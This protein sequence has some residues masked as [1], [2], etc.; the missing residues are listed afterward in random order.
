MVNKTHKIMSKTTQEND[1]NRNH[2]R[3][4]QRRH[5]ELVAAGVNP[6]LAAVCHKVLRLD[7]LRLTQN[8]AAEYLNGEPLPLTAGRR[9]LTGKSLQADTATQRAAQL[10][11]LAEDSGD[12]DDHEQAQQAHADARALHRACVAFHDQSARYHKSQAHPTPTD[13]SDTT[14]PGIEC[15]LEDRPKKVHCSHCGHI[16]ALS[17]DAS[18][19]A[20]H[21]ECPNCGERIDTAQG[22][23]EAFDE[24]GERTT[25]TK[26][27]NRYD[28]EKT[29]LCPRCGDAYT[30]QSAEAA[31]DLVTCEG[32]GEKIN[33]ASALKEQFNEDGK[34]VETGRQ[35]PQTP[36]FIEIACARSLPSFVGTG[37]TLPDYLMYMPEGIHVITPSQGGQPVTVCVL[38][39]AESAENLERQRQAMEATGNKPFFSIQHSTQIAAFWPTKFSWDTRLD[40]SGKLVQ[41]VW[42]DG[43]WSQAGR[44]AVE[45]KN[46]RSFSPTFFVDK[47]SQGPDDPAQVAFNPQAKLNMG[48]LENDPAFQ[49]IAP[50]WSDTGTK[51]RA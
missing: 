26:T 7:S 5:D 3:L 21:T 6:D 18:M 24:K 48:A 29:V 51:P 39:D 8:Q 35:A 47:I 2:C 31:S 44:E 49:T 4:V 15:A 30:L 40:A 37:T 36:Q 20:T 28:P 38:V 19:T 23:R 50:L 43:T 27:P 16:H 45:G 22:I 12:A 9:G 34:P 32:C 33:V 11:K 10:S 41:G 1:F 25:S 46:F 14:A 13:A 42:A 17:P